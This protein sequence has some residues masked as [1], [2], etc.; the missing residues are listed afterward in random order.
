M[1]RPGAIPVFFFSFH[2]SPS[3]VDHEWAHPSMMMEV[4]V[5]VNSKSITKLME[6]KSTCTPRHVLI[7]F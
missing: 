6:R 4:Y 7:T 2:H 5:H 3:D 1:K